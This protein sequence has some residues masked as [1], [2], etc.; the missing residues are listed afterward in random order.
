MLLAGL[1]F[2]SDLSVVVQYIWP[3]ACG[4]TT[5]TG[6][7]PYLQG[8]PKVVPETI[9]HNLTLQCNIRQSQDAWESVCLQHRCVDRDNGFVFG[10]AKLP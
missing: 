1:P 3:N 4:R 7:D 10:V 2:T 8:L 5:H 6:F 9:C